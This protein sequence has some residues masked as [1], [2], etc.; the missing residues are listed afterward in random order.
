M[1]EL[2]EKFATRFGDP[3]S[4]ISVTSS[5]DHQVSSSKDINHFGP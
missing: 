2:A 5:D 1:M 4:Q 3:L